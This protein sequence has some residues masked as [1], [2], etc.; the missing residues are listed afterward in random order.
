[1]ARRT[2]MESKMTKE[3]TED[4]LV[5]STT[6][7]SIYKP[8]IIEIDGKNYEVRHPINKETLEK[9]DELDEQAKKGNL[10][11]WYKQLEIFIGDQPIIPK[12][13]VRT[14]LMIILHITRR[15]VQIRKVSSEQKKELRPGEKTSP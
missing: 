10:K 6:G 15:I 12:L 9:L 5:I 14:V 7:K 8:I 13:D 4:K 2:S 1:M 11:A 3:L